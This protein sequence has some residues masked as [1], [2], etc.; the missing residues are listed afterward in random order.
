MEAIAVGLIVVRGALLILCLVAIGVCL[1]VG[2]PLLVREP[3]AWQQRL[4]GYTA[5]L[6][7][8]TMFMEVTVRTALM[9]GIT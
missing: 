3:A 1:V 8:I 7:V 5:V 6:L 9:G 2:L 4:F